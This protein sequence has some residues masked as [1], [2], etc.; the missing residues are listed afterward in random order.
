[1]FNIDYIELFGNLP[2]ELSVFLI[3]LIPIAELRASIPVALGVY[4]MPVWKAIALS[5]AGDIFV[6]FLI[7]YFLDIVYNFLK[8]RF[9]PVDRF[10]FWLFKRSRKKFFN[11]YEIWGSIALVIFVA[12]PLPATGA[13]TGSIASW[14]FGITKARSL[15]YVSLGVIISAVIVTLISLGALALW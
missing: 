1:M 6:A 11:K 8:G 13:W 4:N 7:I 2:P 9:G 3:S 14:L 15:I 12:I 5:V 10:F